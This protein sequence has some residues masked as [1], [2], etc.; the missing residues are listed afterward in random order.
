MQ[1]ESKD[2]FI[3][4]NTSDTVDAGFEGTI[5]M[6]KKIGGDTFKQEGDAKQEEQ[7]GVKAKLGM[8]TLEIK[9]QK[10]TW[11]C[12]VATAGKKPLRIVAMGKDL[13]KSD[14]MNKFMQS[15]KKQ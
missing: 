4:I 1:L 12:M 11:M 6:L 8:G 3:A 9:G 2:E 14:N 10:M 15:V 7:E 13:E 5:T